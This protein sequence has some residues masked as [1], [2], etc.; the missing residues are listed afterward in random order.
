MSGLTAA[1][2]QQIADRLAARR[3]ELCNEIRTEL[4]RSGHEHFVDL[5][6]EV[7]DAGDASVADMLVDHDIAI[8]RRQVEELA[9][10][11]SAQKRLSNADFGTCEDCGANIGMARLMALP[12]ATRCI[13]CQSQHEK[14]FAHE[15][16]PSL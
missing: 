15:S 4:E 12:H 3:A 11:E 16:T 14:L 6:G 5:A 7:A 10:V 8:V 2:K 13:D 1:Q 9:E